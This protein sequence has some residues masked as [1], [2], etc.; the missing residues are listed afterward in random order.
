MTTTQ[1]TEEYIVTSC[2]NHGEKVV[3]Q[4]ESFRTYVEFATEDDRGWLWDN[5]SQSVT[6]LDHALRWDLANDTD[7]WRCCYHMVIDPLGIL[8]Y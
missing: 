8:D 7:P 2:P 6:R 5:A 4:F 1:S 3:G